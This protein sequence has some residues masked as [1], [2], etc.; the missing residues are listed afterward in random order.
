MTVAGIE[1]LRHLRVLLAQAVQ[2]VSVICESEKWCVWRRRWNVAASEICVV[3]I[4]LRMS[5]TRVHEQCH[6]SVVLATCFLESVLTRLYIDTARAVAMCELIGPPP[7]PD[8][9]G[10]GTGRAPPP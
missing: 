4:R 5:A 7:L 8:A 9:H 3:M 1:V 2:A 6:K 10:F